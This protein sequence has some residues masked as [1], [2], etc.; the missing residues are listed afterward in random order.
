MASFR[1]TSATGISPRSPSNTM[2][3]F[4]SAVNRRRPINTHFH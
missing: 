2:R 3:I 4:S 1:H